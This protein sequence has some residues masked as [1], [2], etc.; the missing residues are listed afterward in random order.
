MT[1]INT[2]LSKERNNLWICLKK[3]M[4]LEEN[5]Q[6]EK[7]NQMESLGSSIIINYIKQYIYY[8]EYF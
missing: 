6:K 7:I 1:L 5:V 2:K 4:K 8:Y 3:R